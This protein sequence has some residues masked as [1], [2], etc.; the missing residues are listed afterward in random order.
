MT[1]DNEGWIE[2]DGKGMPVDGSE[3]VHVV[4][5]SGRKSH[6]QTS[7]VQ[8]VWFDVPGGETSLWNFSSTFP[9]DDIVSYRVV[10]P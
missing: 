3:Y 7:P 9:E 1:D 10:K 6:P 5:R 8:A 2:H 4:F